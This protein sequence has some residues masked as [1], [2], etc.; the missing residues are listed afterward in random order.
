MIEKRYFSKMQINGGYDGS[1][2]D[3]SPPKS[4]EWYPDRLGWHIDTPRTVLKKYPEFKEFHKFL[5]AMNEKGNLSRQE[6]VSMIPALLLEV[7]PHHKVLDTCA[8]P[9]SKTGQLIECLHR[10]DGGGLPTG[11]VIANDADNKRCY[12]L[13]HQTKRLQS[14]NYMITNHDASRFPTMKIAG[15]DGAAVSLKF[16]RVLTDVPCSG[17]GTLRKNPAGWPK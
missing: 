1:R 6:A 14:P 16:D 10:D 7:E 13:A 15:P 11:L 17:D 8:A 3:V 4:I 12:T 9:G 5:V 2:S